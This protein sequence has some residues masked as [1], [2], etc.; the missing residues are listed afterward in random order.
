MEDARIEDVQKYLGSYNKSEN[1][2]FSPYTYP[3]AGVAEDMTDMDGAVLMIL[4]YV[5]KKEAKKNM[6]DSKN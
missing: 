6:N 1:L 5:R 2:T 3:A 4:D